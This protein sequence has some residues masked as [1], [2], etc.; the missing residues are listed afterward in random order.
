MR[1]PP[2]DPER[3]MPSPTGTAAGRG[4]TRSDPIYRVPSHRST[5]HPDGSQRLAH[6]F[7]AA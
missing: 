5:Q 7:A 1:R 2:E 4:T 3:D 6:A